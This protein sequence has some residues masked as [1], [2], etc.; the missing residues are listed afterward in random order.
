MGSSA[1]SV[2][3]FFFFTLFCGWFVFLLN[4]S[5][6]GTK[7]ILS[8]YNTHFWYIAGAIYRT[9]KKIRYSNEFRWAP[10]IIWEKYSTVWGILWENGPLSGSTAYPLLPLLSLSFV[11][12]RS[13][14]FLY[15][16][17][18]ICYFLW[19]YSFFSFLWV[20]YSTP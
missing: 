18:T 13:G 11:L 1:S 17:R 6:S 7:Q 4:P 20:V 2:F 15:V 12:G 16:F 5:V 9:S 14:I 3:F 8:W 19:G 10:K